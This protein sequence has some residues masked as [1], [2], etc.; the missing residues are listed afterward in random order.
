VHDG[1]WA[2]ATLEVAT[3]IVQSGAERREILLTRQ[4]AL[5]RTPGQLAL[6]SAAGCR[7]TY[8]TFG[9]PII[10]QRVPS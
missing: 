8:R 3:A 4:T 1:R 6:G 2:T 9:W 10:T 7:A 5:S